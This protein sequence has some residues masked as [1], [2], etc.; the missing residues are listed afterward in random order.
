MMTLNKQPIRESKN[1]VERETEGKYIKEYEKK[2]GHTEE[3]INFQVVETSVNDDCL[4]S[5]SYLLSVFQHQDKLKGL[6]AVNL[7]IKSN[8]HLG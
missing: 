5:A 8:A 4:C 2:R 7:L 1:R 6:L 3:R